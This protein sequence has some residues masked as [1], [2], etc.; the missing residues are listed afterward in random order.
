[1]Y[2]TYIENSAGGLLYVRVG[3][4]TQYVTGS[5]FII[6]V[7]ADS[8]ANSNGAKLMCGN[9]SYTSQNLLAHS[10]NQVSSSN[11]LST[12]HF[13]ISLQKRNLLIEK[14]VKIIINLTS[15]SSRNP[16]L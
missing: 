5:S 10:K 8:L 9:V 16:A 12:S 1:M 3:A 4:N 6:V 14:T 11:V 2:D 7:L 15:L 13:T